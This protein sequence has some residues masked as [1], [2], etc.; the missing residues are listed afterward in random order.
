MVLA[1]LHPSA[2]EE[3]VPL[4]PSNPATFVR[5]LLDAPEAE[6]NF[7]RA[8]LAVDKFVDPSI[9]DIAALAEIG[10][11]V[12]TVNKMIATLPPDA[13]STSMERVKALRAFL[14]KGGW[15][16]NG[17]PFEYDLS[18]P[19]GQKPGS[20]SLVNYLAT[21][22]GNCVSMPALFIILGQRLGLNVTLST[23]PLH[24]FVKFT[25]DATGKT[26][27]L[28]TTSGA[29]FTRDAWYRQKLEMTDEA[30][31]NGVYL[32][33]LSQREALSI[34]ATPVLDSLIATGRYEEA[35]AVADVLIEA[36][37]ANAYTLVKKGT[38]YYRL[39]DTTIIEK[40]PKQSDIP[41]D[42]IA[43]ANELYQAN[44]QAFAKAEAL[45]W[46]EPKLN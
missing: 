10:S 3:L 1:G 39:L 28:E 42:R 6:M 24:V 20:Q 14:Y 22:K 7:G 21:R 33:T 26:W 5:A 36:Y 4:V 40:Y 2:A 12:V 29:G 16:N 15:W 25:D 9:D 11:M 38:A 44:R 35:I 19:Y 18:D 45:G 43:Y 27:N 32:K 46:R 23:A 34:V 8:K 37:P 30:I 41:A 31:S 13:A 17:R